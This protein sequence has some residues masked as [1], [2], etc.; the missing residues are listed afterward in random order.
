MS[1]SLS[2]V[3]VI[4]PLY[5]ELYCDLALASNVKG[6][7]C[8][9]DGAQNSITIISDRYPDKATVLKNHICRKRKISPLS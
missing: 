8:S 9:T 7:K 6:F 1:T 5:T 2:N 3:N 4:V